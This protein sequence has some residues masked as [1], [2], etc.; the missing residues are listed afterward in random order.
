MATQGISG[1]GLAMATG[2]ALLAYA[3]FTGKNPMQAL[4]DVASGKP[5]AVE[6]KSANLSRSVSTA[7][8]ALTEGELAE[9]GLSPAELAGSSEVV[10]AAYAFVDDK[11]SQ[12][13]R[14]QAG[15]SDCSS[16][17]GKAY[18]KIGIAPPGPSTTWSYLGSPRWKKI[19]R[20]EAKAGDLAVTQAHM[21]IFTSN[22]MGIGQQNPRRNVATGKMSDVM[23]PEGNSF[24][25]LRYVGG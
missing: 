9:G 10:R 7:T 20:S 19:P 4:K 12:A 21:A 8:G 13:K 17:V 2:G 1:V 18:N 23:Y 24:T 5:G 11:Y 15:Y 6:S 25:T 14:W 16:F 3:G 22:S